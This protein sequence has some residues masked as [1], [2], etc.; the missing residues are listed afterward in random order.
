MQSDADTVWTPASSASDPE[1]TATLQHAFGHI[2]PIRKGNPFSCYRCDCNIY[3]CYKVLLHRTTKEK[4]GT[5]RLKCPCH[6]SDADKPSAGSSLVQRFMGEL[7]KLGAI[8]IWDSHCVP[9]NGSMS[10][11]ATVVC[12]HKCAQFEVDGSHHFNEEQQ[13][14]DRRKNSLMNTAGRG[15]MR[16]HYKDINDWGKYIAGH[17]CDSATTVQCTASYRTWLTGEHGDPTIVSV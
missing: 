15:L 13:E 11:D 1:L 6:Y 7:L 5:S 10:I 3:T 17:M 4:T 12:G 2:F 8:V 9:G 14:K 16:L